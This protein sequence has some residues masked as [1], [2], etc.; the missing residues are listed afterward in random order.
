MMPSAPVGLGF[1]GF[2]APAS[3]EPVVAHRTGA[4]QVGFPGLYRPG[5][6]GARPPGP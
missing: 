1:R 6:I 3:L 4:D 2:T 5:L